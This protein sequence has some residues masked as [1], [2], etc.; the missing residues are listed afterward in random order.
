MSGRTTPSPGRATILLLSCSTPFDAVDV[1]MVP[2]TLLPSIELLKDHGRLVQNRLDKVG[3]AGLPVTP[4]VAPS[5]APWAAPAFSFAVPFR[6][7]RLFLGASA[8]C[9]GTLLPVSFSPLTQGLLRACLADRRSCGRKT[10]R[11]RMRCLA[12]GLTPVHSGPESE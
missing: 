11:L 10:R 9:V 4:P 3:A 7:A 1:L 12:S 5:P 2:E 6:L 8:C